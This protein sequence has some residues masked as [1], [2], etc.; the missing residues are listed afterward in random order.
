VINN[1]GH[2]SPC[3]GSFYEEDDFGTVEAGPFRDVWNNK[4]FREARRLYRKRSGSDLICQDCPYTIAWEKYERHK[5][6]GRPPPFESGYTMNDW[7][8]Y[9][10]KK[11]HGRAGTNGAVETIELEPVSSEPERS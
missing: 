9:F 10:F 6:E 5:A 4:N 1:D 2:V 11:R 8:N 7:F 3:A